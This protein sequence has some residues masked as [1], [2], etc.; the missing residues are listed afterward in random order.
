VAHSGFHANSQHGFV[1]PATGFQHLLEVVECGRPLIIADTRT[2]SRW[3]PV[4][5]SDYIRCWLGV[6]LAAQ[7]RVIGLLN[8]DKETP[9]FYAERDAELAAAFANQAAAA[10]ENARLFE[11]ERRQL[12]LSQNLQ[13]VGALLTAQMSLE[14]V[15]EHIFDLLA[16]VVAYDSVSVQLLQPDGGMVLAAGRGFPDLEIARENVRYVAEQRRALEWLQMR[17]M[18]ISDTENDPRWIKTAGTEY[19]RSWIGAALVVKGQL[20]G[21]LTTDS[22]TPHA[23]NAATGETVR[24]FANQAAVAIENARLFEASQRQARALA[25]LYDTALATGSVLETD[26]LLSR[27]YEQVSQLLSPDIFM[28]AFYHADTDELEVAHLVEDGHA[29]HDAVPHGRLP[30][31]HGLSGWVL[32]HRQSLLIGD[33]QAE[34][35]RVPPRQGVR[36]A[37]AWLGVPLIAHERVIGTVSVQAFSPVAFS[38][39]DRR[40][41]ES[42]SSQVAIA[43]EN[44][45][46]YA[47]VSARAAELS[48]LYSAAQDLGAKLEP[49]LVLGQLARHLTEAVGATSGYVLEVSLAAQTISVLAEYWAA[50]ALPQERV[51][52]MGQVYHLPD[53]PTNYRAITRLQVLEKQLDDPALPA[54]ERLELQ[55]YGIR[56]AAVVPLVSRGEVLGQAEVWESRRQRV[57]TLAERRLLQTLCQHAAGVIEN[58][59]LF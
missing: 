4:P 32:R 50:D 11:A 51:S 3:Q 2:D 59:R 13:A 41:L 37:R 5:G 31:S 25:G 16:E 46:L 48:L 47:E 29:A 26:V 49:R 54:S 12:A 35:V 27:L 58:A 39:A 38:Q 10:I 40:L 44:A 17:V 43:I 55:R 14:E 15:F 34:P 21:T 22:A 28:V 20:V 56:S 7:G 30:I 42:L 36:P 33:L 9:N 24:A 57:F 45:R 52:D 53:Y 23:Y 8:L 18:V 6:P 1:A 19:V